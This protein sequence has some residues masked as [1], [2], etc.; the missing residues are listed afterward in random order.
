GNMRIS[1]HS[2]HHIHWSQLWT[3]R[4]RGHHGAH[5]SSL[6][7]R[8]AL[9]SAASA[10][11][12]PRSTHCYFFAILPPHFGPISASFS[13]GGFQIVAICCNFVIKVIFLED[14]LA[15]EN[16]KMES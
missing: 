11:S 12:W 4:V 1:H 15:P 9:L 16:Q 13:R 5:V 8:R 7:V 14:V 3:S 2:E 10:F 6:F